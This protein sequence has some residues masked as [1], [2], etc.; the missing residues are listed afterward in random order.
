MRPAKL[1]L[2]IFISF[3]LAI[4]VSETMIFFLFTDSERRIV[5]YKM[6]QNTIIKVQMLKKL[7]NEKI[8][9]I[10]NADPWGVQELRDLLASVE[11][12]YDASIWVTNTEGIPLIPPRGGGIPLD[13]NLLDSDA[14]RDRSDDLR[15]YYKRIDA[16]AKVYT[17]IPLSP[18]DSGSPVLYVS[19]N[20]HVP[21]QH[22][23]QFS[24]GLLIIGTVVALLI[25][26]VSKFITDRIK[27]LKISALRIAEG[28][29]SHRVTVKARDEIGELGIAFN[30]MAERLE[31]MIV[32]GKELTANISHELRTPL[33]RIR[34]AQEMLSERLERGDFSKCKG[35]MNQIREDIEELD[36]LIGRI[37]D[38]SKLDVHE[39]PLKYEPFSPADLLDELLEKLGPVIVHKKLSIQRKHP[40]ST[41]ING[42]R[43]AFTTAL[44]NILDNAAKFSPEKGVIRISMSPDDSFF[45]ICIANTY[46][47][48]PV[49]D[50]EK[51]F[52]PFYRSKKS[53]AAGT[54]LGLSIA[55]KIIQKHGGRIKAANTRDGFEICVE[56]PMEG[57][58]RVQS[59]KSKAQGRKSKG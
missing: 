24:L 27:E 34:I 47:T 20:I 41:L 5:G 23:W 25:I 30:Q 29:L 17:S 6:E 50:L 12:V 13:I 48:I 55:A 37:L 10:H 2:E 3:C 43:A 40:E 56:L 16:S 38:L 44:S 52:E 1:Y 32:G 45:N 18:S 21:P 11:S 26:P 58:S 59:P 49:L 15:L 28:E 39:A 54:G 19:F 7:I 51:I 14:R 22:R 35:R 46:E 36:T 8:T 42:D 9:N 31:R 4:I 53:S 33:T 57:R